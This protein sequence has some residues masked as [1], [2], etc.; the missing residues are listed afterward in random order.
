MSSVSLECKHLYY[1]GNSL[2][3]FLSAGMLSGHIKY[4]LASSL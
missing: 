2:S 1:V 4:C 3:P